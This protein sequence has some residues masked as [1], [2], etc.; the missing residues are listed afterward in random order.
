MIDLLGEPQI[1]VK[2]VGSARAFGAG[3][4]ALWPTSRTT[5]KSGRAQ[6]AAPDFTGLP[7]GSARTLPAESMDK[8]AASDTA[9]VRQ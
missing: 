5:R 9:M 3:D 2:F 1:E 8:T 4:F 6:L 7:G